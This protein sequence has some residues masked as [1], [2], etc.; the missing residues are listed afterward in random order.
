MT[1]KAVREARLSAYK[2]GQASLKQPVC[3]LKKPVPLFC[4]D[5]A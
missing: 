3:P 2:D 5:E 1:W 4:I